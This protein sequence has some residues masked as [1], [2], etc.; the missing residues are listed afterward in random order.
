M[1]EVRAVDLQPIGT[2]NPGQV[3]HTHVPLCSFGWCLVDA[4][5]MEISAALW[6]LVAQEG[7]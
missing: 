5:I 2:Y 4:M 1:F 7:L 3:V 6:A